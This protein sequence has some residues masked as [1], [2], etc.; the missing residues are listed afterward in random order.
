MICKNC[1]NETSDAAFCEVCGARLDT[2]DHP[3]SEVE[4][5]EQRYYDIDDNGKKP[6][7][8][9]KKPLI[10]GIAAAA[11]LIIG[12]VGIAFASSISE[13]FR[14][15]FSSPEDY[16]RYV[17][18]NALKNGAETFSDSYDSYLENLEK[19]NNG[20][21]ADLAL[22]LED[23]GRSLLGTVIPADITWLK[24]ISL[25]ANSRFADSSSGSEM[26]LYLNDDKILTFQQEIDLE[27]Q[28]MYMKI[29]DFS[30]S[31]LLMDFAEILESSDADLA[32]SLDFSGMALQL[33]DYCPDG[34]T[35]ANILNRYGEI[36]FNNISEV[37]K[38]KETLEVDGISQKC[39][40]LEATIKP[41][42]LT[43]MGQEVIDE[44]KNDKDI[45]KIIR[46]F[47][48]DA[49]DLDPNGDIPDA[50]TLYQQFT[51][52][53]DEA[54]DEL[55]NT[56]E[57]TDNDYF[58]SK[59]WVGSGS[60]IIGRDFS[61]VFDGETERVLHYARPQQKKDFA[62]EA[63][64]TAEDSSLSLEGSGQ[65]VSNKENSAYTFSID[66]TPVFTMEAEDYDLKETKDGSAGG[67]LLFSPC[68]GLTE[69]MEED[70]YNGF[71]LLSNYSLKI[72]FNKASDSKQMDITVLS[73]DVPM[74]TISL[75]TSYNAEVPSHL[76]EDADTVYDL[77]DEE[78]LMDYIM[79]INWDGFVDTLKN[80]DIPSEYTELIE[81][82]I[83]ELQ[84][85]LELYSQYY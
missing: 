13:F 57:E 74:F 64:L 58:I 56:A 41:A 67:S 69:L 28:K 38:E 25:K 22:K 20:C 84:A 85:S 26:S 55:N 1:G 32:S 46:A 17:E 81:S 50:D 24:E 14:Q 39:T 31:Y 44:L 6:D 80:S 43:K 51:E 30:D 54:M 79:S 61:L 3:A 59:I 72:S 4:T 48:D 11:V 29:P 52:A 16:Y 37:K 8:N 18:M 2:A 35:A 73:A 62:L 34:E 71:S 49:Q 5:Q 36:I 68:P 9:W 66:E 45:E 12:G 10:I 77:T 60:Q 53:L 70:A 21:N 27:L 82:G 75:A 76:P 40:A 83:K 63:S 65:I 7:K 33:S 47:A 42:E 15:T 78:A 23:G 19:M